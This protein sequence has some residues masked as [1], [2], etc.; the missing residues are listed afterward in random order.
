MHHANQKHNMLVFLSFWDF[1]LL[2]EREVTVVFSL[3]TCLDLVSLA[4]LFLY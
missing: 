1:S 4:F 3:V 2:E